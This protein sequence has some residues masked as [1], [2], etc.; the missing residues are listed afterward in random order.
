[1]P[2]RVRTQQIPFPTGGYIHRTPFAPVLSQSSGTRGKIWK[3]CSDATGRAQDHPCEIILDDRSGL[4][5]LNGSQGTRTYKDYYG[6]VW[7]SRVESHL[8]VSL[9]SEGM[10]ATTLLA[11]T[12]PSRPSVSLINF[13]VELK[14]LPGM[15][16]DIG[17]IKLNKLPV[18][19]PK[20]L[21][22]ANLAAQMGWIPLIS[23]IA[24]LIDFKSAAAKRV[25]ELRKL[26]SH[27]G[28]KRRLNLGTY[29]AEG[30]DAFT[31]ESA[32]SLVLSTKR[33]RSTVVNTWGTVRWKPTAVPNIP[34]D[35]KEML[36]VCKA[37]VLG[38]NLRPEYLWNAIP[39]SWLIDYAANVGE[40]LTAHNNTVP[41]VATKVNVMTQTTTTSVWTRTD[42]NQWVR[43][44]TGL[45]LYRTKKRAQPTPTL[46]ASLPF[47]NARQLSILGSL[48]VQRVA[49]GRKRT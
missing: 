6:S 34:L 28:L 1:M 44:G 45:T 36:D 10:M 30:S 39:W 48:A 41:A 46:S 31:L 8:A 42:S 27:S 29:G 24:K 32:T 4:L 25:E 40:Y 14:D 11:R 12:N 38:A 18:R 15:L 13:I 22:N 26:Y 49:G 17:R 23:D 2:T 20:D 5:G 21:A 47:L 35:S 3:Y 7:W 9:P 37:I 19:S 33:Y 43:G 16:R